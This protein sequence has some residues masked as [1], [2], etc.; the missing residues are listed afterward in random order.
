MY[1]QESSIWPLMASMLAGLLGVWL[2]STLASDTSAQARHTM[3]S[4]LPTPDVTGRVILE[5]RTSNSGTQVC[6]NGGCVVTADDGSYSFDDVTPGTYTLTAVHVSYL[7]SWRTV[8]VP[9]GL[10][11]VP[12]LILLGGDINQDDHIGLADANL[13]G[14]A[15]N[16]TPGDASWDERADV[17]D[18]GFVNILDLVAIQFNWDGT[19]PGP[20]PSAAVER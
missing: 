10:L 20:W 8:S 5:R 11:T 7:R 2:I 3:I 14:Q 1:R 16:G 19:A 12:D 13:V 15:W 6:L 9:E 17:T 4:P 18:D